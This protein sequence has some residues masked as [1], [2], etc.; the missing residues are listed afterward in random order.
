MAT[1]AAVPPSEAWP[2]ADAVAALL[3][4]RTKDRNGNELGHWTADTRPTDTDV[5]LLIGT[6]AQGVSD[7]LPG[8]VPIDLYGS[9][10]W[11]TLLMTVCLIEKSYFPEQIAAGASAYEQYWTEYLRA[12]AAL[13]DLVAGQGEGLAASGIGNLGLRRPYRGWCTRWGLGSPPGFPE[14]ANAVVNYDDPCD[15]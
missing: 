7:E 11:V 9:F 1:R 4:A 10:S 15:D 14:L 6:A 13:K 12:V 5:S 8:D 2:T 3:R